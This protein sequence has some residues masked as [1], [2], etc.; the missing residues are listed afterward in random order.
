MVQIIYG[1]VVLGCRE[2]AER[3]IVSLAKEQITK[4][5]KNSIFTCVFF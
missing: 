4:P 3:Q 2:R 5:I 1:Y